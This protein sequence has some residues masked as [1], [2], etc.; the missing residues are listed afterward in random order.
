MKASYYLLI[1]AIATGAMFTAC[2]RGVDDE[3]I[4]PVET[5]TDIDPAPIADPAGT[6]NE[7]YEVEA[8]ETDPATA[9][10]VSRTPASNQAGAPDVSVTTTQPVTQ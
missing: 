4:E 7:T 2:D 9:N 10:E 6:T 5:T 8:V 1:A 3:A